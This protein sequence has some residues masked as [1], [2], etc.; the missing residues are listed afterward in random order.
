MRVLNYRKY[1]LFAEDLSKEAGTI[2]LNHLGKIKKISYKSKI[3]LVTDVDTK[4]ERL[5]LK[6]IKDV[7]SEHEIISEEAGT[8][9]SNS[10]DYQWLIDPLDGT[11]NY[12]H[13]FGFFCVSIA[14]L[15]KGE[16]IVGVVYDP[17][18]DELFSASKD[19]GS[20]LNGK[21]ISVSSIESLKRS[22]LA[23]GFPYSLGK[24]LQRNMDNF[25]RFILKSQAVRRAG[26]A[27]L[28][29]CYVAAGRFDGFWELGLHPWDTA[30]GFIIVQEAG[31]KVT[32]FNNKQFNPFLK[33]IVATNRSL[34][35]KIIKVLR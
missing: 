25:K 11:T 16:V 24:L 31:G 34:H 2:L 8:V 1:K 28:D 12:A 9:G 30:A 18:R 22:L 14:L 4:C 10:S 26:S 21:R 15:Y 23:T 20:Y 27:A 35:N 7:F 29:L 13:S 17:L 32:T 6:R 5:I 19:K 3:D 33:E